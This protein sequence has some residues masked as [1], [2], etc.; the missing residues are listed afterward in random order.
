M[1]TST[2]LEGAVYGRDR[3][4]RN[5]DK[6]PVCFRIE[7]TFR[8]H[9]KNCPEKVAKEQKESKMLYDRIAKGREFQEGDKVLLLLLG[10][11][12]VLM[13]GKGPYIIVSR[14]EKVINIR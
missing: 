3:W 4:D 5:Q 1:W 2:A 12:K 9:R 8:Q 14:C 10:T 13:Q 11:N 7:K 6:L